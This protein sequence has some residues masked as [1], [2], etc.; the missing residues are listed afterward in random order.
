MA[1]IQLPAALRRMSPARRFGSG[2]SQP[3]PFARAMMLATL[4]QARESSSEIRAYSNTPR[5][6][7]P[8][9]TG[10]S[11]PKYPSSAIRA[12][13]LAGIS[14]CCGSSSLATGSTSSIA[15]L[16]AVR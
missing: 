11:S 16:R 14:P 15:K 12:S 1:P 5:P 8:S 4:S 3:V 2:L 7:P 10:M 6:R 9:V 13:R